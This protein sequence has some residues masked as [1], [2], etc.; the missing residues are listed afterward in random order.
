MDQGIVFYNTQNQIFTFNELIDEISLYLKK[1]PSHFYK[2]VIGSDTKAVT[3]T[4][5]TTVVAVLRVGNGGRYFWSH[6]PLQEF[7]SLKDRIYREAV[8]SATLAQE[9][10]SKL[11]EK[12]GEDFFW[13]NHIS[14]HIDI[15]QRGPS[16]KLI[17]SLTGMIRGFGFEP[18]IKPESFA[19]FVLADRH[20]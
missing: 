10:R 5:I 7:Y 18:V 13:N 6:S 17:E 19:A 4:R 16:Q 11:K 8:A 14:V 12:F 20:T 9:I 2:I 3:E 1:E 15:G